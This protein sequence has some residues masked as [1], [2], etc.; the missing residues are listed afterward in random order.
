[1]ELLKGIDSLYVAIELAIV[2]VFCV[3]LGRPCPFGCCQ[4][5]CVVKLDVV[6]V[7]DSDSAH[8]D[9]MVWSNSCDVGVDLHEIN[10][11][12]RGQRK[13]ADGDICKFGKGL[14]S[15]CIL[16]SVA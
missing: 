9:I 7:H 8:D 5:H 13:L 14:N 3:K 4:H 15:Y 6:A 10:N 16:V 2:E 11:L 1:M 12:I